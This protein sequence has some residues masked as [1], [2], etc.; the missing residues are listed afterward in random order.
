MNH[1]TDETIVKIE[2]E[3]TKW[4]E[5]LNITVGVVLF[6]LGVSCLGSPDP[7]VTA[8]FS[9][10]FASLLLFHISYKFPA[11]LKEL[12]KKRL[13]GV[14]EV[15]LGGIENKHLGCVALLKN[16]YVFFAGW[17]F[18]VFVWLYEFSK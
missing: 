16:F 13:Q 11:T 12:R 2:V 17:L 1:I 6:N 3:F 4:T 18:L 10:A 15:T 9:T 5:T 14:D 8:S 7:K